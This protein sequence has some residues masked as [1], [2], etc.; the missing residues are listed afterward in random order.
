[1]TEA[2]VTPNV[3]AWA[4]RRRGLEPPELAP[5]LHV[6]PEAIVAWE[7]GD[8]RPTFRQAQLLAQALYVPFG[9]LFLSAPPVQELPI[10]DFRTFPGQPP[11]EPS[12]QFLDLLNDVLT[13][14]QWFRE[15]RESEGAEE[16]PFVGAFAATDPV[17]TI[18][19][20]IRRN[21]DVDG[22]RNR[23]P[24]WEGFLR[25]LTRNAEESGIMVMRS[26][27][28]GNNGHRP[29]SV[30]EFRGFAITDKMAPVI[31]VNGRDFRGAQI[32]TFAHE[33]AHIWTGE[34]GISNPDYARRSEGQY[35]AVEQFSNRVAAETLVPS[36]DFERRWQDGGVS[37]E[38]NLALLS[39]IF[40]VSRMVI[41]R[42]AY[43]LDLV[44]TEEYQRQYG[45]LV[46][47]ARGS[48]PA[49]DSG[50]N[51]YYTLMARNGAKFTSAVLSSVAEGSLLYREAAHLLGV[52]VQTLSA[53]AGHLFHNRVTIG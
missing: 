49:A 31:F 37:V 21:I 1:M 50:G 20:D 15:Y 45:R 52:Q 19:D 25:E 41:L 44:D 32:F 2:L 36:D 38:R 11:Q 12:H 26:G 42:Q 24:N 7:A 27:I 51:F 22:A 10:P 33:L 14:Q 29:L 4:R 5:R 16:L 35:S 53:V 3:L 8:Q 17:S 13:K 40:R 39:P 48:E 9:H 28:V 46:A 43:D 6:R 30:E 47:S 18:A 34:A 23:A